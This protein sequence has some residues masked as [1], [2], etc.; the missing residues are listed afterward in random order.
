[1]LKVIFTVDT[2]IWCDDWTDLDARFP[3]A[4]NKYVY[5]PTQQGKYALPGLFR[6]LTEHGLTGV[7]MVETLF[8]GR[9]GRIGRTQRAVPRANVFLQPPVVLIRKF[10]GVGNRNGAPGGPLLRGIPA[11]QTTADPSFEH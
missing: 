8:A 1:M 4:F 2:E 5:G 7:F 10:L 9:F 6:I 3:D 11:N